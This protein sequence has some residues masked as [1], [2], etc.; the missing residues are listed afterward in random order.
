M[1]DSE[2][3]VGTLVSTK[4][5]LQVLWLSVTASWGLT[6]LM[7]IRRN[8][9]DEE[10][11]WTFGQ[12][13]SVVLFASPLFIVL[14]RLAIFCEGTPCQH[15]TAI[16]I[17]TN[18][19]DRLRQSVG[20]NNETAQGDE[21][22]AYGNETCRNEVEVLL[23][24]P[25]SWNSSITRVV[26]IVHVF[27]NATLVA[28]L[29]TL[30][31]DGRRSFVVQLIFLFLYYVMYQPMLSV[32]LMLVGL[33]LEFREGSWYRGR[34]FFWLALLVSTLVFFVSTWAF[35]T[36]II[37]STPGYHKL[38]DSEHVSMISLPMA[39]LWLAYMGMQLAGQTS[40]S[41]D[42]GNEAGNC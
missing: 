36:V 38:K 23:D 11:N 42:L 24:T 19:S 16:I 25:S 5:D 27:F 7:G 10:D 8:R 14:E 30:S 6:R 9:P 3:Y 12:V 18:S 34:R 35:L 37:P 1:G 31:P 32:A 4:P 39:L 2:P 26:T 17:L 20:Q 28:I 41:R 21:A 22:P 13:A 15:V 29:F 33:R 40:P